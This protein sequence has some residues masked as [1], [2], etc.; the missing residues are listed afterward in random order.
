MVTVNDGLAFWFYF[1]MK[2]ILR[3]SFGERERKLHVINDNDLSRLW[4]Q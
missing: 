3:H 4:M 2:K 1:M